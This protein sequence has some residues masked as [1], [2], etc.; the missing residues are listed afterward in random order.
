MEYYEERGGKSTFTGTGSHLTMNDAKLK[1][2]TN[3]TNVF[4][5]FF[6]TI[7][8][9]LYIQQLEKGVAISVLRDLFLWKLPQHKKIPITEAQIKSII[10][11]LKPKKSQVMMK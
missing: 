3:V 9:K 8:K 4:N 6:I 11:S 7:T 2:A 10:H 1:D 5:N